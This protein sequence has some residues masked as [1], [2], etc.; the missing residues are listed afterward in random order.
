MDSFDFPLR[1]ILPAVQYCS[2]FVIL[3][4]NVEFPKLV[5]ERE[6]GFEEYCGIQTHNSMNKATLF[7]LNRTWW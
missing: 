3:P 4:L 6:I 1:D 5:E 2:I 7:E